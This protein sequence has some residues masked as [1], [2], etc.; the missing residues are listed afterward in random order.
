MENADDGIAIAAPCIDRKKN[1]SRI[2]GIIFAMVKLKV[3]GNFGFT[4]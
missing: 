3:I 1:A 4:I 2:W